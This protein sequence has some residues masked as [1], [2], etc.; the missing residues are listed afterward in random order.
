M[1]NLI[2]SEFFKLKKSLS[3]K[4]MLALSVGVGLMF[5]FLGISGSSQATGDQ[6]LLSMFSFVMFHTI[7]TSAFTAAFFVVNFPIVL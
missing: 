1:K 3:Y 6:M 7:F 5:G 4:V 2:K